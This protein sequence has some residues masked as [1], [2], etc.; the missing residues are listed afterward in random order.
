MKNRYFFP[1]RPLLGS[2]ALGLLSLTAALAQEPAAVLLRDAAAVP[3]PLAAALAQARPLVLDVAAARAVL[4]TAPPEAATTAAPLVLALP[5]PDGGTGRFAVWQTAVMAPALAARFPGIHTYAGYGLDDATATVR[6][7]LTPA[8]FHAQ[9]LS[10]ITGTVYIDPAR[11]DEARHYLSFF[12]RDR[13]RSAAEAGACG[14][15]PQLKDAVGRLA[16]QQRVGPGGGGPLAIASGGVLRTYR[17]AVATTGEYAAFHGGTVAS[18][19][20]A[21]VTT[22]NRVVGVY[23]KELA[24][25]LVLVPNNNLLINLNASTDPYTNSNGG[26]MLDENQANVDALI[27]NANYDI[28]HVFSTGGGGIAGYAVVCDAATKAQ[29][30]TGSASPVGDSFD[31]DYVAHEMGHQFSGSHPFNGTTGS[32]GGGNRSPEAAWEPGSGSTIMGYAGICPQQNLQPNSDAFFHV[33]NYEE[34]RNFIVTT[35]CAVVSATTNTPPAVSGPANGLIMPYGT[36][37]RLTATAADAEADA[38]TYSWEELDLGT[39]GSPTATQVANNNVPLFR[40][41]APSASPTRYFPKL[42]NLVANRI[43]IGERLPTVTR[44]LTFKCTARDQHRSPVGVIGGVSSSDS[45]KLLVTRSAGPFAVTAPNTALT[46]AGGSTQTVTWAVAGTD[47]NGVN[48]ATVNIRLST[49]GGLT[50]PTAL[51]LGVPNAGTATVQVPSVA[52]A[53]ARVMVEAVDNYFFDISNANFTIN[54]P[55]VCAPAT[56]LT[57]STVTN[58]SASLSFVPAA[59]VLRYTVST[60]PATTTQIVTASPVSLTGLAPGTAYVVSLVSDCGGNSASV[61]AT[62]SFTT[63][64]PPLCSAPTELAISNRAMTT[65]TLNFVPSASAIS[66]TVSTVPATTT[67]TVTGGPVSLTGLAASTRYVVRVV[68]NCAGGATSPTATLRFRTVAPVPGNDL[69]SNAIS[70]ACGV[71]VTGYTESATATDDPTLTC[72]NTTVDGGGVFYTLAG[73]GGRA[74]VSTCGAATDFDTKLFVYQGTCGGPY[75]CITANDDAGG[76]CGA[77]S[78]VSFATAL[79]ATYLVFVG[80]YGSESGNFTLLATCT[81]PTATVTAAGAT[82]QVWPNPVGDHAALRVRLAIPAVAATATLRNVLGQRLLQHAFTGT[83]TEI[84]TTGLAVGTYF[85]TV[86]VA[87]QAPAVRRVV[88]E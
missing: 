80:G 1:L 72:S 41:F 75:T 82:F 15:V 66:Y 6:L 29:G 37:F 22:I 5:L 39:A 52:S 9:I 28:G 31:I 7:D 23:E 50:Y 77:A 59:G 12:G 25:R 78:T 61:A 26:A 33:G 20:A 34:M 38:L 55:S 42:T 69:C 87:G 11:R 51:A 83:I 32:C 48:C 79:G 60:T 74:T 35:P 68:A 40:S 46:W 16:R 70:L 63:T 86:Q 44:A 4:A 21:I 54:S 19:Q 10:A 13:Q 27:G 24:V 53:T 62:A 2:L 49:D 43:V 58:T 57:V 73:T 88:V 56:A 8:G 67:Q 47:A 65:A 84:T 14:F 36:P 17:L 76:S 18:V 85:L 30:V 45:V 81:T 3:S 71:R 64:A